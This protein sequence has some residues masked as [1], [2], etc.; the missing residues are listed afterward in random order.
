MQHLVVE[1]FGRPRS[2]SSELESAIAIDVAIA[3]GASEASLARHSCFPAGQ[4]ISRSCMHFID[5][6][7]HIAVV[8]RGPARVNH[9]ENY[10]SSVTADTRELE[11]DE[12]LALA[13]TPKFVLSNSPAS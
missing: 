12:L 13:C 4:F 10:C 1:R 7:T 2:S 3:G 8:H 5:T 9:L 6:C 11:S